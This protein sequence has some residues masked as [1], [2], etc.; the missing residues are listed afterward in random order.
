[1]HRYNVTLPLSGG[2]PQPGEF[3]RINFQSTLFFPLFVILPCA[4]LYEDDIHRYLA[5]ILLQMQG[6]CS[7]ITEAE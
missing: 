3:L 4:P 1:M 7:T 2:L 6:N 5:T